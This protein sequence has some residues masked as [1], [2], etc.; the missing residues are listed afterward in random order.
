[1]ALLE[2]GAA[3]HADLEDISHTLRASLEP[4]E[5]HCVRLLVAVV[6]I[7]AKS[8]TY[9]FK[10][11]RTSGTFTKAAS[12]AQS[13]ALPAAPADL[14]CCL[15]FVAVPV[16]FSAPRFF[17]CGVS[18]TAAVPSKDWGAG[19]IHFPSGPRLEPFGG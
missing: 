19:R 15:S 17:P 3:F 5:E 11:L 13:F 16:R 6:P 9:W 8:F 1:M 7:V 18:V 4:L 14:R 2:A 12:S 10:A